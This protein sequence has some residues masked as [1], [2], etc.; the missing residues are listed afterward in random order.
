[1]EEHSCCQMTKMLNLL[2]DYMNYRK[3]RY[4]RLDGSSAIEDR[5]DMVKDFQSNPEIFVFLLR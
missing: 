3:Y 5:R 2:E 4:V 1:M